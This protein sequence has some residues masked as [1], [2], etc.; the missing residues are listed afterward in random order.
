MPVHGPGASRTIAC[1]LSAFSLDERRRYDVLRASVI[2]ALKEVVKTDAG[3]Q[4]RLDAALAPRDIA[5]WMA[6][7]RR[8]CPFLEAG[9][10][11]KPDDTTWVE[12]SGPAG[13]KDL[14]RQEF[15]PLER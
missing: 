9:F 7:E 8:C 10:T 6:L 2:S 11:L 12:L 13:V 14:L 15:C 3:F 4:L 1:D 5:E